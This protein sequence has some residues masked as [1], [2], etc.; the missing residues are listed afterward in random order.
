MNLEKLSVWTERKGRYEYSLLHLYGEK[1][2]RKNYSGPCCTTLNVNNLCAFTDIED[3]Q[4]H[5]RYFTSSYWMDPLNE[6]KP[7][8]FHNLMFNLEEQLC[9]TTLKRLPFFKIIL[10]SCRNRGEKR[11][12]DNETSKVLFDDYPLICH[13]SCLLN[14]IYIIVSCSLNRINLC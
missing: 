14:I 5:F 10:C 3:L 11:R 1:G 7:D 9:P 13:K 2:S 6:I 4:I 12:L 8:L